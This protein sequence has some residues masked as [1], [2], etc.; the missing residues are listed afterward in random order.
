MGFENL[1][2]KNFAQAKRDVGVSYLGNTAHSSKLLHSMERVNVLTYGIYLA[3]SDLSGYNVCPNSSTCRDS[4]LFRSGQ[5]MMDILSGKNTAVISRINKTKLFFE[6]REYFMEWMIAEIKLA[7][8]KAELNGNFFAIRLNCTS[9]I[10]I[11]DFNFKGQNICEIFPETVM[12]DYTKVYSYLDNTIKYPN[13]SLT[14]SFNGLNWGLCEKALN[15]GVNV[16][17]VFSSKELP[18]TFH[19]YRVIDGDVSDYRPND[20]KNV[21]VGLKYKVESNA[22]KNRKF[23]MPKIPFIVTKENVFCEW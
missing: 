23:T 14:Y 12:Y 9:D 1:E 2:Y 20:D 7:K 4:C 3:P 11:S 13:Y 15:K 19:G 21:I 5:T 8:L 10:S 17:V 22:I 16:A 18:R 6:N